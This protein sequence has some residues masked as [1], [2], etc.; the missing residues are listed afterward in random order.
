[1]TELWTPYSRTRTS[2]GPGLC[3]FPPCQEKA[4]G[5]VTDKKTK[6]KTRGCA[7]HIQEFMAQQI[8]HKRTSTSDTL[9]PPSVIERIDACTNPVQVHEI[10]SEL[11]FEGKGKYASKSAKR[12]WTKTAE[13]KLASFKTAAAMAAAQSPRI[14]LP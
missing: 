5:E 7:N 1:M 4:V 12:Q 9:R 6:R 13:A 14:I 8:E 3:E 11:F 10:L 2:E